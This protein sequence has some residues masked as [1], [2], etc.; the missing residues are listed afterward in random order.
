ME[1]G[2]ADNDYM[3]GLPPWL[4]VRPLRFTTSNKGK[5]INKE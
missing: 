2:L 4:P 1:T 3:G 5:Y